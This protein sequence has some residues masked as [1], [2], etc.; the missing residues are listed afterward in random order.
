M[1]HC[2]RTDGADAAL[3]GRKHPPRRGGR[4]PGVCRCANRR[5]KAV[6]LFFA[7]R[8]VGMAPLI[9]VG[10]DLVGPRE[11]SARR[12]PADERVRSSVDSFLAVARVGMD[13]PG[14]LGS[15]QMQQHLN[16]CGDAGDVGAGFYR[17]EREFS[18]L[19][20]NSRQVSAWTSDGTDTAE[21]N[22]FY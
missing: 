11:G 4:A 16:V 17:M 20:C 5:E 6:R 15:M 13:P 18:L 10:G 9:V 14:H 21:A 2:L 1:H 8:Y 3:S 19:P 22:L 12:C 7:G